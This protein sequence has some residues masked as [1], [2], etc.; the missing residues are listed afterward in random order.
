MGQKKGRA[1][2][3]FVRETSA[4]AVEFYR[5]LLQHLK[6]WTAP[7][8]K[9]RTEAKSTELAV[10]PEDVVHP[11]LLGGWW[12]QSPSTKEKPDEAAR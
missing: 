2:E 3:S 6:P 10:E 4:Q 1:E 9:L 7:A 12:C 8:P 11:V 5:D